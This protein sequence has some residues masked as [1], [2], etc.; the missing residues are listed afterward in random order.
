MQ[1]CTCYLTPFNCPQGKA[2]RDES[3]RRLEEHLKNTYIPLG[4]KWMVLFPEGG[5]LTKRRPISQ[6]FA[7]KNN[8]PVLQ[9]VTLP[10]MGALYVIR[11]Q[12]MGGRPVD[13]A[14]GL[15]EDGPK[16][17]TEQCIN[18]LNNNSSSHINKN[19]V[20]AD[21]HMESSGE[22]EVNGTMQEKLILEEKKEEDR[23]QLD[24]ILDITIG[25]PD[26]GKPLNLQ[27]IVMGLRDPC[28]TVFYYRVYS[29][30]EV[31]HR[32]FNRSWRNHI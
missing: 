7:A 19:T 15:M 10:R 32:M 21:H 3:V 9:N 6:R 4:R 12:L 29:T 22:K 5:F 30:R 25:Y 8:M 24:Y 27:N 14:C 23:P 11:D 20:V 2:R 13:S 17:N 16:D 1:L 18:N 31:S 26:G 28:Q